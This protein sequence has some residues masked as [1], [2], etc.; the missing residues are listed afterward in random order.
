MGVVDSLSDVVVDV[1]EEKESVEML[2]AE[3]EG[4]DSQKSRYIPQVDLG[5]RLSFMEGDREGRG[6]WEGSA[7][8]PRTSRTSR[9]SLR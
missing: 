5:E 3:R 9:G 6:F 7:I 8:R 1:D 2:V 4:Q